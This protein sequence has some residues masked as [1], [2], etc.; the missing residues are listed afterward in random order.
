M[1]T[2]I[3]S[4]YRSITASFDHLDRETNEVWTDATGATVGGVAYTYNNAGETLTADNTGPD[5]S[6]IASYTYTY[7]T[8]GNVQT[9]HVAL[10]GDEQRRYPGRRLRL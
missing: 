1:T 9:E 8:T 7:T 3:D 2:T 10:G 5:S 6:A 4:D